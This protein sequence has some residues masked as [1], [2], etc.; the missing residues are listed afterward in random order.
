MRKNFSSAVRGLLSRAVIAVLVLQNFAFAVPV[1]QAAQLG[2]GVQHAGAAVTPMIVATDTQHYALRSDGT[3]WYW[4]S[5]APTSPTQAV[6]SGDPST[7]L[8]GVKAIAA[9][10]Y[11]GNAIVLKSDGNVWSGVGASNPSHVVDSADPSGFVTD[12]IAVSSSTIGAHFLKSDGSVWYWTGFSDPTLVSG[13]SNITALAQGEY[14]ALFLKSDG[15]VWGVG[16][17]FWGTLGDNQD[18]STTNCPTPVQVH[19]PGN[20]G[21]LTGVTGITAGSEHSAAVLSD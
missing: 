8:T 9:I 7:F 1:T 2:S 3:V 13:L 4:G 19:G 15:T 21:F 14:F 12:V 11:Q 20:V 6:D 17:N 5:G 18:C 16:D 10:G